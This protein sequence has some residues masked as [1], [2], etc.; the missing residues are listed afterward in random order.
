MNSFQTTNYAGRK[1]WY[2]LG[3]VWLIW[4]ILMAFMGLWHLAVATSAVFAFGLIDDLFGTGEEKGFKGHLTAASKGRI[5]TGFAK[6]IGISVISLI[7]ALTSSSFVNTYDGIALIGIAHL[8][9]A[10]IALT[11]NFLNLMDLRPGR[12]AKVYLF[13]ILASTLIAAIAPHNSY[14]LPPSIVT[15]VILFA[16]PILTVIVPDLR[17]RAMLGDAGANAAGFVAGVFAVSVMPH[18][19]IAIYV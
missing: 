17:E 19:A 8:A 13:L 7:Y 12:A 14:S 4:A 10:A 11:S 5:T 16:L 9:G 15:F 6:L 3:F 2:G 18:W 1:V